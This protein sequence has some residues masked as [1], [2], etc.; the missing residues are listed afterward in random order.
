MEA[1]VKNKS[2]TFNKGLASLMFI[3]SEDGDNKPGDGEIKKL[4]SHCLN[5]VPD[6]G[7]DSMLADYFILS[8]ISSRLKHK[9]KIEI[10]TDLI[11]RFSGLRAKDES[12]EKAGHW[13]TVG[14]WLPFADGHM[15][16]SN[17]IPAI[18]YQ[19]FFQGVDAVEPLVIKFNK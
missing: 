5:S 14:N 2:D 11:S 13:K 3:I 7:E 6:V 19:S 10:L 16:F 15:F 17:I 9:H 4:I 1:L 12:A 8:Q 18:I